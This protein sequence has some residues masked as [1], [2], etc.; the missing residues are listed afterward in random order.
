MLWLWIVLL[1][2][3]SRLWLSIGLL[4]DL[5]YLCCFYFG[6]YLVMELIM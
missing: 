4:L 2:F 3:F 1:I 5:C 6:I